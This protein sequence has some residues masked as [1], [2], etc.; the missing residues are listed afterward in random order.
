MNNINK[1]NNSE[2][3]TI[4]YNDQNP[5]YYNIRLTF[6]K[7][8]GNLATATLYKPFNEKQK[9][10]KNILPTIIK[11]SADYE[12]KRNLAF[13]N[14]EKLLELYNKLVDLNDEIG[15]EVETEIAEQLVYWYW[16]LMVRRKSQIEKKRGEN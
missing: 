2:D 6:D 9:E 11:W 5:S 7:I 15:Y 10:Y 13:I 16:N 14:H 8:I 1:E 4:I 12:L 3:I